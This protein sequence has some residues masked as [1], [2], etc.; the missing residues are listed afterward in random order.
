MTD[1][2]S[3]APGS[4]PESGPGSATAGDAVAEGLARR[5]LQWDAAYCAVAG[6]AIAAFASAIEQQLDMSA[7][8]VATIGIAAVGW[9][10]FLAWLARDVDWRRAAGIAATAN[11]LAA[12]VIGYWAVIRGGA[13][14]IIL[15]LLALQIAAFGVAGAWA[16]VDR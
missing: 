14:G 7:W 5:T 16:L 3:E 6:I 13:G 4:E 9:S 8:V 12:A 11:A 1:I 10:G 2:P 15:G